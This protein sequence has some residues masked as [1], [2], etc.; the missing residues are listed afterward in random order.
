[1]SW[2]VLVSAPYMQPVIDRFRPIF[3]KYDIELLVPPV[4]ERLEEEDLLQLINDIDGVI[5][6]RKKTYFN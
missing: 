3:G 6:L 5:S 1:M 2:K 4:N